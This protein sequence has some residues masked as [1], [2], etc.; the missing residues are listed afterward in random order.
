LTNQSFD[1]AHVAAFVWLCEGNGVA[2]CPCARGAANAVHVVCCLHR[3]IV[4]NDECNSLHIDTTCSN[5]GRN[6]HAILSILE[7]GKRFFALT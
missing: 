7:S 3:H 5:V 2:I 4:V 6:K 1:I